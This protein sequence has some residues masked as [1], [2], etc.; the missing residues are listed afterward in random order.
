VDIKSGKSLS[1]HLNNFHLLQLSASV[2]EFMLRARLG[3]SATIGSTIFFR[4]RQSVRQRMTLRVRHVN[5]R[6]CNYRQYNF[7]RQRQSVKQNVQV[8]VCLWYP[9]SPTLVRLCSSSSA[10]TKKIQA[11]PFFLMSTEFV[12]DATC[13]LRHTR[14]ASKPM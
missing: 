11:I 2:V 9:L 3:A 12:S 13:R 14:S 5:Y 8:L 6:Q 1:T 4:Q 7:F 10:S